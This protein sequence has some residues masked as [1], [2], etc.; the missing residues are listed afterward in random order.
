MSGETNLKK[1]I[2]EMTPRLNEGEYI[3]ATVKDL[4]SI[5][6]EDTL[7]EFKE[8]EGVTVVM[9]KDKADARQL[10]YDYVASWITLTVHSSLDAVGLTAAFSTELAKHAISCNVVAGYHHDHI[11]VN[12]NDAKQA[13]EVLT[14]MEG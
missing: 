8:A 2:R 6:R 9:R 10:S 12:K 4:S 7:G 13:M 5:N 1:L 14:K 3:F 11:F